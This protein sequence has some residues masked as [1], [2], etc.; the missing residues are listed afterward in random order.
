MPLIGL[1]TGTRLGEIV[2]LHTADVMKTRGIHY[3]D[4]SPSD[5]KENPKF[6]KTAASVRR[7]P[8]HAVLWEC[9]FLEFVERRKNEGSVR[10]FPDYDRTAAKRSYSDKFS[11]Y[12]RRFLNH[13]G[14]KRSKNCF[15]SFRHSFE[16]ACRN[17]GVSEGIMDALQGHSTGG[18]SGRYGSGYGLKALSE[19]MQRIRYDGLDLSHLR[20]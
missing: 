20:G 4:I 7:I 3:I 18:M 11:K 16:D 10:L 13:V 14:I 6:V 17:S 19:A 15:H 5:D 9:G 2:Q 12:F 8:V 1:F